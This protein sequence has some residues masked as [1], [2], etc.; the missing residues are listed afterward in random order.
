MYYNWG[1]AESGKY[2]CVMAFTKGDLVQ[3][4]KEATLKIRLKKLL[5]FFIYFYYNYFI[6]IFMTLKKASE[7]LYDGRAIT[8]TCFWSCHDNAFKL[9]FL[10]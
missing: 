2:D 5:K 1:G 10:F 9:N 4:K 6:F 7:A 8:S 3:Q